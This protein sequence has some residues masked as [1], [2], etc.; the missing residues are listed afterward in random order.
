MTNLDHAYTS[1]YV[2]ICT[3]MH[4]LVFKE[5]LAIWR[6]QVRASSYNSNKSTNKM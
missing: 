6:F 2:L 5:I 1:V 3:V 4:D